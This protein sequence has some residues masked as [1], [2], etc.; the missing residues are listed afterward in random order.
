MAPAEE[1]LERSGERDEGSNAGVRRTDFYEFIFD[2][3]GELDRNVEEVLDWSLPHLMERLAAK[4][5][6]KAR[7]ELMTLNTLTSVVGAAVGGKKGSKQ[8]N[9]WSDVLNEKA[10]WGL[11]EA[12][13]L[14]KEASNFLKTSKSN[15]NK[16]KMAD[17]SIAKI[18]LERKRLREKK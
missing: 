11:S 12:E 9:K 16:K 4:S 10:G 2:A 5:R 1:S 15:A 17:A 13:K 3:A 14:S 18:Q 8:L 6:V 7:N